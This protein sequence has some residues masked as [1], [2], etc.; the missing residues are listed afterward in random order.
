MYI[1]Y[2][3]LNTEHYSEKGS[4]HT[5]LTTD[6]YPTVLLNIESSKLIGNFPIQNV[7]ATIGFD[8]YI[9]AI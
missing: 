6:I 3:V 5:F 9:P 1:Q 4:M 8:M 7:L 2:W